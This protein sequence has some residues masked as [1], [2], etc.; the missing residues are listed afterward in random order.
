MIYELISDI[1]KKIEQDDAKFSS[2]T[3]EQI[4]FYA[5]KYSSL[6]FTKSINDIKIEPVR[7]FTD[8]LFLMYH[9]KACECNLIQMIEWK[10]SKFIAEFDII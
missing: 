10:N 9:M 6:N 3:Y 4:F 2:K 1:E 5:Y 7:L 8:L